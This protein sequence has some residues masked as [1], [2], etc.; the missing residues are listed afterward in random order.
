MKKP[1]TNG[2]LPSKMANAPMPIGRSARKAK[3]A[4]NQITSDQIAR[5]M[6]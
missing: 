3:V 6:T 5:L 1:N 2:A 4:T